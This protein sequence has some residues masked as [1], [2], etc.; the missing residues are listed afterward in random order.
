M[1]PVYRREWVERSTM[2]DIDIHRMRFS[3]CGEI[4]YHS[5][6]ARAFYTE[7]KRNE[8]VDMGIAIDAGRRNGR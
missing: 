2:E 5:G 1:E 6:A 8:I 4:G 3:L 7:G